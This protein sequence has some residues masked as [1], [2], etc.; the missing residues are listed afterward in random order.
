MTY[1]FK[2]NF[3]GNHWASRL[4]VGMDGHALYDNT[5][6]TYVIMYHS[7]SSAFMSNKTPRGSK[8]HHESTNPGS[9]WT[10][11]AGFF[12]ILP[13]DGLV[14]KVR[15]SLGMPVLTQNSSILHW[16]LHDPRHFSE[17]KGSW[18]HPLKIYGFICDT[19]FFNC[20]HAHKA[21]S[22]ETIISED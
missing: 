10:A 2:A 1:L 19:M 6:K 8:E 14:H 13:S 11:K 9:C 18:K 5:K 22:N 20:T 4:Y 17:S 12:L 16:A 7:F 3:P 15:D 21:H